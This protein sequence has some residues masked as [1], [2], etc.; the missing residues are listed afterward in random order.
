V[1]IDASATM[2]HVA[3][4]DTENANVAY[5]RGDACEVPFRADSFDAVCCFAALYLIEHPMRAIDE[6]V[7]V[8]APGGR[9]ALLAS[10]NRGLVP[11]RIT[12]AAVRRLSGVR[13]FARDELRQALADRRLISIEQ[14]V[15]GF[16]QFVSARK[17]S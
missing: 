17:P 16:A 3:A 4:R 7:R 9:V 14:R 2:L 11:A 6:I 13:I 15:S 8:L 1:G 10:C 12:N 5:I